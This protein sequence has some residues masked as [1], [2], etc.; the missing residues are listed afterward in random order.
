MCRLPG[1]ANFKLNSPELYPWKMGGQKRP[2]HWLVTCPL[3][4]PTIIKMPYKAQI[5]SQTSQ[6]AI[7][8]RVHTWFP[9]MVPE[10]GTR[11][12]KCEHTIFQVSRP[13]FRFLNGR[14]RVPA[15]TRFL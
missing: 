13:K 11:W 5:L 12:H 8:G 3:I 10:Y 4:Q 7:K 14:H 9:G 2:Q 15:C 1:W 6:H